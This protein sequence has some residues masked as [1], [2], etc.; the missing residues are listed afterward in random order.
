M[1]DLVE[2]ALEHTGIGFERLDGSMTLKQRSSALQR[3][4]GEISCRVLLA[5]V[6][7]AGVG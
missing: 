3:F 2:I 6:Q 4:S 1:L 7:C 5:S